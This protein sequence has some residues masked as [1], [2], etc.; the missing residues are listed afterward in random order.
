MQRRFFWEVA[1]PLSGSQWRGWLPLFWIL[2]EIYSNFVQYAP[3]R[4][5]ESVHVERRRGLGSH[6][7]EGGVV[8]K[9]SVQTIQ[10][11]AEPLGVPMEELLR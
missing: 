8:T 7:I 2:C 4:A 3:L 11:I 9:P 10:K 1:I 5:G 6:K